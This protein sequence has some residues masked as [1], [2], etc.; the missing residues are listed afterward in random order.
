MGPVPPSPQ[1]AEPVPG[2]LVHPHLLDKLRIY[3]VTDREQTGGR[4][5][6]EVVEAALI[7]GV[8]AVQLRERGLTTREL[9]DLA[10]RLRD[11]TAR[12]DALLVV[13]DRIDVARA[14]QADGAHL[15]ERSFS[16]A[17]A[18]A[19]L[20][21][22]RLVAVSAHSVEAVRSAQTDGADFTVFGPV[23]DTPS[24]RALGRPV[25]LD[26]LERASAGSRIPVLAIGGVTADL[27]PE[28]MARGAAGAALI[29]AIVAAPDPERSARSLVDVVT[30]RSRPGN[31][32]ARPAAQLKDR[33][34]G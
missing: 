23:F 30:K 32:A 20:G 5:L 29:R 6:C 26:A 34:P 33:P 2:A 31:T 1:L 28:V 12:Y 7:G 15:P 22:D 18:R 8:R 13:N 21:P 27:L 11:L 17:D 24:K 3:L 4:P 9:V 10:C 16:V 19:L 14:C 25:G